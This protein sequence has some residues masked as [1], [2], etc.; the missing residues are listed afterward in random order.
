MYKILVIWLYLYI[1]WEGVRSGRGGEVGDS[2][3]ITISGCGSEGATFG[4]V[5]VGSW[6]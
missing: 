5:W 1:I 2:G 6:R 4:R 3:G